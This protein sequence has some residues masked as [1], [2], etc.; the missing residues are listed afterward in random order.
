MGEHLVLFPKPWHLDHETGWDLRDISET[1]N[2]RA[3]GL[4]SKKNMGGLQGL[5]NIAP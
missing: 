4:P 5:V 3:K 2:I 1:L